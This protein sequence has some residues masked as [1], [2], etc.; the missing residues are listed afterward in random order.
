[1]TARGDSTRYH[2]GSQLQ[3][4]KD[5]GYWSSGNSSGDSSPLDSDSSG[6]DDDDDDGN[7]TT[8]YYDIGTIEFFMD[9]RG[10]ASCL[11]TWSGVW[12]VDQQT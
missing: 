12:E 4:R 8:W 7:P 5:S 11:V 10:D 6:D 3:R 2:S 9:V 1:M